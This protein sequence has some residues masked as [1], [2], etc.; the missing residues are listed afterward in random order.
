[1]MR[2]GMPPI[3]KVIDLGLSASLSSDV[4]CTL[5]AD[6]FT[7]MRGVLTLQRML[8]NELALQG[9]DELGGLTRSFADMTQQLS[10]TRE[11]LRRFF[12]VDAQFITLTALQGLVQEG[13]LEGA[14]AEKAVRELD[15]D[16]EKLDPATT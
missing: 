4:E 13:A 11:A 12:E 9:K 7:Q 2:H 10:D 15:I 5:T 6:M 8:A 14:V 16:P 1:M 3:Q